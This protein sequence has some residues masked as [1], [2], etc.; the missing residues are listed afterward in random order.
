MGKTP[1]LY[2]S[3]FENTFIVQADASNTGTRE[4][5]QAIKGTYNVGADCMY[6]EAG[7]LMLLFLRFVK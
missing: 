3:D 4:V 2:W 6:E 7:G 1:I 5:F